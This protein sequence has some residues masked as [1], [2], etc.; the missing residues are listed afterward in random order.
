ML[1]HEIV[2]VWK[3][4]KFVSKEVESGTE[5]LS[6]GENPVGHIIYT[7]GGHVATIAVGTDRKASASPNPS[8]LE[9]A[10]LLR[11]MFAYSGTYRVD[12]DWVVHDVE[13]S[14]HQGWTG[15]TQRRKAVLG[16]KVLTLTT[17]P[18]KGV[19]SGKEI[20]ATITWER[21]E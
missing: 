6:F 7:P 13:T 9:R 15:T 2:G 14:W 4:V 19:Q 12:G 20:V 16:G 21:I 11:S 3:L 18:Y 10:E 1:T 17:P 5:H 8:D